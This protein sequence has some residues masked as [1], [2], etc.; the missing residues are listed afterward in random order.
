MILPRRRP[1]GT[2]EVNAVPLHALS[3]L[4][5]LPMHPFLLKLNFSV[6]QTGQA[7]EV[8]PHADVAMQVAMSPVQPD[9]AAEPS[10]CFG[11]SPV[12]YC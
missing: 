9:R 1:A 12:G 10:E 2:R 11:V 7:K 8:A 4:A 6:R 3:G 5:H